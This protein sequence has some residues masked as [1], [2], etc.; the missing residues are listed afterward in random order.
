MNIWANLYAKLLQLKRGLSMWSIPLLGVLV[1]SVLILLMAL[2]VNYPDSAEHLA[3]ISGTLVP[4]ISIVL[5]SL[6]FRKGVEQ[7]ITSLAGVLDRRISAGPTGVQFAGQQ[8]DPQLTD[9]QVQQLH[10]DIQSLTEQKAGETASAWYFFVR[11][12]SATIYGTQVKF[13]ISLR[14]DGPKSTEDLLS[15]YVMFRERAP[16]EAGY[17]LHAYISYLVSNTL[18]QHDPSTNKYTITES[19]KYF[20]DYF[21]QYVGLWNSRRG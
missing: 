2:V 1:F 5:L 19:G 15:S 4:W 21:S 18:I 14:D 16:N 3:E 12:I 20:L 8:Q 13:L 10:N 7:I 11:Y 17:P 9:E 6:V